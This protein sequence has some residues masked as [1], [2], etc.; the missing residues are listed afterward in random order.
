MNGSVTKDRSETRQAY[1][2]SIEKT[3]DRRSR[4]RVHHDAGDTD[5]A[6]FLLA[7]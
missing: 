6:S 2:R 5:F 1:I 7:L 4:S 3:R